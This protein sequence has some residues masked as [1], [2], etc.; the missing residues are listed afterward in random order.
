MGTKKIIFKENNSMMKNPLIDVERKHKKGWS[1]GS[2]TV[3]LPKGYKRYNR[4]RNLIIS[5][6]KIKGLVFNL[7]NKKNQKRSRKSS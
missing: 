7:K 4:I 5:E 3:L 6:K 2:L 1:I